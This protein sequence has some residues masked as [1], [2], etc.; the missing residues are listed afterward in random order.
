MARD[1]TKMY[2]ESDVADFA[3]DDSKRVKYGRPADMAVLRIH[4]IICL[5]LNYRV[6]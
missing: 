2:A 4:R 1:V 3:V 5:H 6:V